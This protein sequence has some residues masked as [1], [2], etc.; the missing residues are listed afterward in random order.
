MFCNLATWRWIWSTASAPRW[1]KS[2]PSQALTPME[3]CLLSTL[4]EHLGQV[5]S[6]ACLMM[7][8]CGTR[9]TWAN[10]RTLKEY[11]YWLQSKVEDDPS[12]PR[13]TV[14][15]WMSTFARQ[16]TTSFETAQLTS[17]ATGI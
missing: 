4:A 10:T 13:H 2:Q 14:T 15:H 5:L 16:C 17:K 1:K 9:M 12:H 11:I 6:R 8:R 3:S 7:K